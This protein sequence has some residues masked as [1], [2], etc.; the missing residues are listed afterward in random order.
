MVDAT[1]NVDT[2]DIPAGF[3]T[4]MGYYINTP[5]SD[6]GPTLSSDDQM[7]VFTSRRNVNNY[8]IRPKANEDLYYAFK[9]DSV[10][11]D[12]SLPFKGLNTQYNEGSACLSRDGNVMYFS[13]CESPDG[14]GD[15]DSK[16]M[17]FAGIMAYMVEPEDIAFV[18]GKFL[19]ILVGNE[20]FSENTDEFVRKLQEYRRSSGDVKSEEDRPVVSGH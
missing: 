2:L 5:Y 9:Y 14:Y 12:S 13:R 16:S 6:Y 20:R 19:I 10:S 17:L 4:N 3:N 8:G 1:S 7:I 18:E 15:C 11:W